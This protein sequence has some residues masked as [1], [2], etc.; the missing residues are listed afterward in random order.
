MIE[1]T[2]LWKIYNGVWAAEL[3]RLAPRLALGA[4]IFTV[5]SILQAKISLEKRE[6]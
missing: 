5:F 2:Q 6:F 3:S 4:L 1:T